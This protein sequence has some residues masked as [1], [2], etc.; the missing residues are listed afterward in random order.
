MSRVMHWHECQEKDCKE[1]ILLQDKQEYCPK[2][3]S[4]DIET[5]KEWDE[6][7]KECLGLSRFNRFNNKE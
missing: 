7:T 2:C 4:D 6:P 1:S 5:V 3:G